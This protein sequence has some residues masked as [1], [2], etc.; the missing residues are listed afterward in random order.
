MPMSKKLVLVD[1]HAVFHRAYHAMPPLTTSKGELVNAVFGFTSML[2]RAIADIKPDYI[3]VAFDTADPTFRHQEYTAYKAQR[4]AA[5]EELHEQLPRV[6]EVLETLNIPIFE[7]SGYE[8][9]D[10]IGTLA[11]QGS[12]DK[13][14]QTVIVTGDRDTLQLV[15][16]NVKVYSPGKS[17]ADVIYFDERAVKEKYGV[18]PEKI[19]DI[20][21]LAGDSSDNI[22]GVR[23][24]GAKGATKLIQ[25]FGSVDN[26]Y[27]NLNKIPEKYRKLLET[28]AEAAVM[29]KKLATI[30]TKTPVRL[31]L[32]KCVLKDYDKSEVAKLFQELEFKSLL[33]KLP[34]VKK[35]E[36]SNLNES[37]NQV[38]LFDKEKESK[39]GMSDELDRVLREM[40]DTGVLIDRK[41]LSVLAEEVN[42]KLETIEKKIYKEVGHEFNLNSPKQLSGVLYDEL[43]LEPERMTRTKT[44]KSTNEATLSTLVGAHPVIEPILQYREL[45]KLKSTYIDPL[46][47][48]IG[49]DGRIHTHYHADTTRTGRLSSKDPNLQNIPARGEWGE[50]VRSAFIA[51]KGAVLLSADYN[52]IEL[53]VMAHMCGDK[54]LA[55]IFSEGEDIHTQAAVAVLSK[56]PKEVTKEDR[57]TAKIINF[58]IMYG[59]SPYGLAQQ[60]KIDPSEAKDIIDRYFSRFPA[61][62]D[63]I[64]ATLREA[65][66][67]G[68]VETLGGFKRYVL[69]LRSNNMIVRKAGE[70]IAVNSPIQGTAADIIKKA[71]VDLDQ[72]L[73]TKKFKSKMLL[74]VHD[75]LVFE[76]PEKETKKIAELVKET[77][78][79]AYKLNVPLIVDLKSG[80]NWGQMKNLKA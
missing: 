42:K 37:K 73:K 24:I 4:G 69:E 27:K 20:K 44:H 11:D 46:P 65:Y 21:G 74:Q 36:L 49:P 41:K 58:G 35:G 26:V 30:D 23:G 47:T 72:E 39:T 6:K 28:D 77:M 14:L 80:K 48:Q 63:W 25:E 33:N 70:R 18:G 79:G 68:Y 43:N 1:G 71:M 2:L 50:K 32:K 13:D 9:D 52:Q 16:P 56:K 34:G 40:E 17:F 67:N 29:S 31:D 62:Q 12:K 53:R 75:E 76:V 55:R 66:E 5:P 59:I 15:K 57:R 61:V 3:A 19:V 10:I 64:G 22:P 60:L 38:G 8:A 7:L 45:F 78:E 54:E 51:P